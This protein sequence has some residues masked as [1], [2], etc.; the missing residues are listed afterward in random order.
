M[1]VVP[2]R[3]CNFVIRGIK[4]LPMKS[5]LCMAG[6]AALLCFA[7]EIGRADEGSLAFM[8]SSSFATKA[9]QGALSIASS[10]SA[11]PHRAT[12]EKCGGVCQSDADC[13]CD[14]SFTMDC[15]CCGPRW[16]VSLGGVALHRNS[17]VPEQIAHAVGSNV[18][19]S[20]ASDFN[21]N[22]LAL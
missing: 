5:R 15:N 20:D 3:C 13:G 9:D 19:I 17:N 10:A 4:V 7:A 8:N 14:S 12:C 18:T 16:T 1:P 21:F 22:Y 11:P 2:R 6:V